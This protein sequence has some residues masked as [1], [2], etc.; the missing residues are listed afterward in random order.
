[1]RKSRFTESQIVAVLKGAEAG[2]P[3]TELVRKHGMVTEHG[4]K[5]ASATACEATPAHT[6]ASAVRGATAVESNLGESQRGERRWAQYWLEDSQPVRQTRE[7][8]ARRHSQGYIRP[9][10]VRGER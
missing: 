8:M 9:R 4:L 1:M 7:R 3:I 10:L 5:V 6:P 2:V